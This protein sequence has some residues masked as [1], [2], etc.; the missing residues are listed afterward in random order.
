VT[1]QTTVSAIAAS[2]SR[3]QSVTKKAI[4]RCRRVTLK[5]VGQGAKGIGQRQGNGEKEKGGTK[6]KVSACGP[7]CSFLLTFGS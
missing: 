7:P 4:A 1:I 2:T 6:K 3:T 5:I